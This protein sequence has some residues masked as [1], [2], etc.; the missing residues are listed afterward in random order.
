MSFFYPQTSRIMKFCKEV[1]KRGKGGEGMEE[2]VPYSPSYE[3][4]KKTAEQIKRLLH[5]L[6]YAQAMD[7]LGMVQAELSSS[8]VIWTDEQ[9]GF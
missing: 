5:G 4:A 9:K 1:Y 3:R 6:T 2:M 7:A 8:A